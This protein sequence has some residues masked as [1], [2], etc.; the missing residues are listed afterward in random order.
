MTHEQYPMLIFIMAISMMVTLTV[1]DSQYYYPSREKWCKEQITKEFLEYKNNTVSTNFDMFIW[2]KGNPEYITVCTVDVCHN[3]TY[4]QRGIFQ[5]R[6][7]D[8][9]FGNKKENCATKYYDIK[10][11]K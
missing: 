11:I 4:E 7:S 8:V 1:I 10:E 3:V 5:E 6:E 2:H 9:L